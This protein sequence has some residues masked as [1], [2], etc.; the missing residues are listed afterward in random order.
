QPT[1]DRRAQPVPSSV[2]TAS[3][4]TDNEGTG[5]FRSRC[6]DSTSMTGQP[7]LPCGAVRTALSA[8]LDDEDPGTPAAT[9]ADHLDT[10][11]GCRDWL[12]H[13]QRLAVR[14][15]GEAPDLTSGILAAVAADAASR[16]D[17]D[18]DRLWRRTLQVATVA[19]AAVQLALAVPDLLGALG[20]G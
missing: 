12:A 8:Q 17:A 13:A 9:L 6:D 16:R 14:V 18:P 10:C 7:S 5:N 4:V 1:R 2:G 20:V 3:Q 15:P 11:A 19:I